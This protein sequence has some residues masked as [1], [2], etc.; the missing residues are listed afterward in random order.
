M[1]LENSSTMSQSNKNNCISTALHAS[2][3]YSQD[4]KQELESIKTKNINGTPQH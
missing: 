3:G 4:T 1:Q 2:D